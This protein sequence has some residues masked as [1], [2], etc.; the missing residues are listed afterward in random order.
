MPFWGRIA[1]Q[2]FQLFMLMHGAYFKL[3]V[4]QK[5][6]KLTIVTPTSSL[7]P[8]SPLLGGGGARGGLSPTPTKRL[9]SANPN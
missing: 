2:I 5:N 4:G 1:V 3:I 9:L 6:P 7:I 8:M